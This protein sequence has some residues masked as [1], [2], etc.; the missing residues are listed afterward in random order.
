MLTVQPRQS[1]PLLEAGNGVDISPTGQ[2]LLER[3][4]LVFE[5]FGIFSESYFIQEH[6]LIHL[7]PLWSVCELQWD[8]LSDGYG[9]MPLE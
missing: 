8:P 1:D 9:G 6:C 7:W 4:I 3:S 5:A 2:I